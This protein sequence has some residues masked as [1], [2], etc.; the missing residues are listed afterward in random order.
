MASFPVA[1]VLPEI[2]TSANIALSRW[3]GMIQENQKQFAEYMATL[4]RQGQIGS[5]LCLED[6]VAVIQ[7][8]IETQGKT[9]IKIGELVDSTWDDS[10]S[11]SSSLFSNKILALCVYIAFEFDKESG[12]VTASDGS[13]IPI[14][15]NFNS[16]SNYEGS[17]EY[18]VIA[19]S[20]FDSAMNQLSGARDISTGNSDGYTYK[21]LAKREDSHSAYNVDALNV[22]VSG[23]DVSQNYITTVD[24]TVRVLV[25]IAILKTTDSWSTA[26]VIDSVVPYDVDSSLT[27]MTQ[28]WRLPYIVDQIVTGNSGFSK[29]KNNFD[30]DINGNINIDGN[31]SVSDTLS[32][33]D[34][35]VSG[36]ISHT[37][38][39][40][41]LSVSRTQVFGSETALSAG[42]SDSLKLSGTVISYAEVNAGSGFNC[43]ADNVHKQGELIPTSLNFNV[44]WSSGHKTLFLTPSLDS[45]NQPRFTINSSGGGTTCDL[46]VKGM[47]E[48]D[49]LKQ[50][51]KI[52]MFWTSANPTGYSNSVWC[53]KFPDGSTDTNIVLSSLVTALGTLRNNNRVF[54]LA[55]TTSNTIKLYTPSDTLPDYSN[56][57]FYNFGLV[58]SV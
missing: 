5:S 26:D 33:G 10:I 11:M 2:N 16:I 24:S 7:G 56:Y 51:L 47:L 50:G 12:T 20:D 25:P 21:R 29:A 28:T 55:E 48:A 52:G 6:D 35:S 1:P 53:Y 31:A 57:A 9:K 27:G 54:I 32:C 40:T 49:I 13:I 22:Y 34:F 14:E 19:F 36:S 58:F 44:P 45:S 18:K 38:D 39:D 15:E 42:I 4:V 8:C 46:I 37:V 30:V 43:W 41:S 3:N 23:I 17:M